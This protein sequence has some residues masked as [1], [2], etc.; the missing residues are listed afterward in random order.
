M[1]NKKIAYI[2]DFCFI[3]DD[4]NNSYT[5]VGMPEEYFSRFFES[6]IN[7]ISIISRNK[8]IKNEK[9][10]NSG[11]IKIK[12][13]NINIPIRINNYLYL[14]NPLILYKITKELKKQDLLVINFPSIIGIYIWIINFF[15]RKPYTLEVAAD[16][17]QFKSKKMGFL[18]TFFIKNIFFYVVKKSQGG[19]YVSNYL[20]KKYEHNNGMVISNV[21]I[22][23]IFSRKKIVDEILKKEKI[24]I[25]FAGG[26]NKRKGIPQLILAIEKII[27]SGAINNLEVN[28]AGGHFDHDYKNEI[29]KKGLE[30]YI[31]FLGII[32]K[33]ELN[34]HLQNS[35][36]YIQPSLSEG[37]P[38]ATLEAMSFG[39]PI[40][41][42][43]IPGF[44]EILPDICLVSPNNYQELSDK[45]LEL[46]KDKALYN[47]LIN[48][49]LNYIPDYLFD[50]LQERRVSFYKKILEKI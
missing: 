35:D 18:L 40:I 26:V 47:S 15:V 28:I 42:T 29:I 16:S 8:I 14:L 17:D 32:D 41:A 3:I 45:I 44:Q 30:K 37:I 33:K 2:H 20:L 6:N 1:I 25:F 11:F 46:L 13:E 10:K 7:N 12:N 50:K 31:N 21:N 24:K 39:I 27:S 48:Y 36:I 9:I 19:I 23:R 4:N 5:A 34:Q 38:R 22:H 49:N 43:R